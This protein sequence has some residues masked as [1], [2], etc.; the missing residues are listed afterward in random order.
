MRLTITQTICDQRTKAPPVENADLSGQTAII[1]GANT[2]LGLEAVKH[3]AKMN[4]GRIILACRN[5]AKGK[6]AIE[7]VKQETG[8]TKSELWLVDLSKFSSILEFAE[9]FDRDGGRLDLLVMNAGIIMPQYEATPDNWEYTLQV[10]HI[11]T[12]LLSLL[13]LP[14]L[15]KTAKQA[16]TTPRLVVVSSE[17]HYWATISKKEQESP[18]ILEQL[19]NEEYCT[20]SVM[21]G[22]YSLSKLLNVFFIRALNAHMLP[23]MPLIAIAV[24]PGYCTTELRRSFTFPF[25]AID[26][27]TEKA[28]AFTGEEGSRQLVYA[29]VGERGD[30]IKLRGSYISLSQIK[31]SSDFVLSE[32]GTKVQDRIWAETIDVLSQVSPK[33]RTIVREHLLDHAQVQP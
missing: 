19:N 23:T 26:W 2:G 6:V 18:K 22:R 1:V 32:E 24:N 12:S 17:L 9:K 31:E 20:P 5:E 16:S 30:E 13:L 10:N 8:Y 33:V 28:L 29:A 25:N 4:A 11:G 15:L 3:F 14:H 27:V 21:K 7:N